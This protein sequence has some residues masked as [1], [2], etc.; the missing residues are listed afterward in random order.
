MGTDGVDTLVEPLVQLHIHTEPLSFTDLTAADV[1]GQGSTVTRNPEG[2]KT[3]KSNK[4]S[5]KFKRGGVKQD[6]KVHEGFGPST[7]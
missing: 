4:V 2:H 7:K 1:D 5:K 3:S 6:L